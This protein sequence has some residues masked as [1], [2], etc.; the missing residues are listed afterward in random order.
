MSEV[1]VGEHHIQPVPHQH[2]RRPPRTRRPRRA[3]RHRRNP[4]E[5]Y[6]TH[7]HRPPPQNRGRPA[8]DQPTTTSDRRHHPDKI[9]NRVTALALGAR[10]PVGIVTV[11]SVCKRHAAR[12]RRPGRRNVAREGCSEGFCL[13][14]LEL[15]RVA[16]CAEPDVEGESDDVSVRYASVGVAA[17][18]SALELKD[19]GDGM[20][21][22]SALVCRFLMTSRVS[23]C[24][25][26]WS[27]G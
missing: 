25:L 15:G 8:T 21:E 9:T 22:L 20:V 2:H 14:R 19:F 23:G 18:D 11:A 4:L 12:L 3:D 10:R 27:S 16:L 1:L 24:G 17:A 5:T 13:P 6:R 7:R 26:R